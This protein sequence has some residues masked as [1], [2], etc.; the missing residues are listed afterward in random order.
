MDLLEEQTPMTWN[1]D[2]L[3]ELNHRVEQCA[4]K[5][6]MNLRFDAVDQQLS[7]LDDRL[8]GRLDGIDDRLD[9]LGGRLDGLSERFDR[10]LHA[11]VVIS[12]GF[13]G[14]VL[15]AAIG[16]IAVVLL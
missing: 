9:G 3:D 15:A 13:A 1:D 8:S 10:L 6:E 7:A 16:V 5:V 11:L 2:R 12:W 14:T 4:T